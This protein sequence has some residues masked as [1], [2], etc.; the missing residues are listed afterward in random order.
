MPTLSGLRRRGFTPDSIRDFCRR[1]GVT[2]QENLIEYELLEYCIREDLDKHA[3]RAMAVLNPIKVLIENYPQDQVETLKLPNHPQCA[4]M[5][6]REVPFSREIY[7]DRADF[8][9]VPPPKYKRLTLAKEVR[10]RGA[11]VIR[12]DRVIKNEQGEVVELICTY[13]PD[14]L[15]KNPEGRKVKGVIHWVAAATAET[16]EVRLY[17]RLF[18]VP[19]PDKAEGEYIDYLNPE[20]LEVLTEAKVEPSLRQSQVGGSFQFEREGYF[21]VDPDSTDN[22]LIFNR[23]V[24]LRDGWAKQQQ[25]K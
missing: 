8:E 18:T 24:S 16:A 11:Y 25:K 14:T 6:Q 22:R 17:D 12:C 21:C 13:D 2:K 15:G 10:L 7:I 1:V 4:E 5:G 20:S 19:Q 9:E 3:P 23:T